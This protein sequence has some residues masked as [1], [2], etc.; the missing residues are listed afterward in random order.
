MQTPLL[1]PHVL[2]AGGGIGGLS[3]GIACAQK[4][5][6]VRLYERS[7]PV[8]DVGAG[9]QLGPNVTRILDAWGVLPR[10]AQQACEPER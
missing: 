3:A 5:L 9:I 8:G 7:T 10:L 1:S 2:I 6:T 4:G